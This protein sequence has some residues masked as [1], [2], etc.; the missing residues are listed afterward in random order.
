MLAVVFLFHDQRASAHR[1]LDGLALGLDPA[2]RPG[3]LG[4]IIRKEQ[5]ACPVF[6]KHQACLQPVRREHLGIHLLVGDHDVRHLI[7]A[8]I[9]IRILGRINL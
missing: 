8:R 1:V 9:F 4:D 3:E 5:E 6:I 7:V 2:V